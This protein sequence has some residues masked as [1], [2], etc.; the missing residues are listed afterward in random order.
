MDP[1]AK[2]IAEAFRS[3][4]MCYVRG[5]RAPGWEQNVS[6]AAVL[7]YQAGVM[8]DDPESLYELAKMYLTGQGIA[9]NPRL[10]VHY[11]FS[12]A[13]KRY[14]PAQAMLGSL[15]YEGKVLK[16]QSVNG[17][18][19][20]MLA[21]DGAKSEEKPWIDRVYQDALLTASRDEEGQAQRLPRNGSGPMRPT[22]P[23]RR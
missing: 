10:A 4:A 14:A 12:A 13:R 21:L 15:M 8:L 19:L 3:W 2:L 5:A 23:A 6:R 17:L 7:F 11:F 22:R 1:A 9:Q 16:R 18:A 20:M